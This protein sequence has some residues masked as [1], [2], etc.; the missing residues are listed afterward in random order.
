MTSP[1][2]AS[3]IA[4]AFPRFFN[5]GGC[6]I[7]S[8][9]VFLCVGVYLGILLS[10]AVGD[11]SGIGPLRLGIGCLLCAILGMVGARLFHLGVHYRTYRRQGLLR[12]A[13]NPQRSG[14]SVFGGLVIVPV[15]LAFD[16]FIGVPVPVFWDHMAF[17]IAF[18]GAWIRFGCVCNGCCV[19]K[20]SQ[21]WFALR[22]HDV[23][24]V[25]RRRL[26]VQWLEIG[27][28][29]LAVLGLF[30]LWPLRLPSGSYAL[31]VLCWY[32]LGRFWLE[33]MREVPDKV[34]GG[35]RINQV[36][37]AALAGGAGGALFLL[38]T[39]PR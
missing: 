23:H 34:L 31:G 15:T 3:S 19:G 13:W 35:V 30:W 39:T 4:P 22:Q 1:A 9:K 5:I 2:Q 7:N 32:G 17:G 24:G 16:T 33:P 10:A 37:A 26:P 14:W 20:P 12:D 18:G 25:T 8:Y 28:W 27:W 36:V 29:L 38:T 11:Q 21:C 6:W